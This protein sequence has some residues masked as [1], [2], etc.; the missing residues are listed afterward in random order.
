LTQRSKVYDKKDPFNNYD[1]NSD[2][3]NGTVTTHISAAGRK[4]EGGH[5]SD[6]DIEMGKIVVE[7]VIER[8]GTIDEVEAE[9]KSRRSHRSTEE[10]FDRRM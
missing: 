6:A 4:E 9:S 2:G 8:E 7:E 10:L 5:I 1:R 3:I